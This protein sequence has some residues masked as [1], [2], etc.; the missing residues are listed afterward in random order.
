MS[1]VRSMTRMTTTIF[2]IEFSSLHDKHVCLYA[3]VCVPV[4]VLHELNMVVA[5]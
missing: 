4:R 3:C 5:L 2:T 1:W